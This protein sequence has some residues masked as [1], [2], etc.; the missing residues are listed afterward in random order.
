M[1]HNTLPWR[2]EHACFRAW[3][4]LRDERISGWL[5]RFSEGLTRRANSANP[6]QTTL[7][8]P[9]HLIAACESRYRAHGLPMF[10]RI[11]S[12]ID[13]AMLECLER[14]GYKA[15]G[16]SLVMYG[17][18]EEA[19]AQP[20]D[21]TEL[22]SK[23]NE[24]WL[25][26]MSAL[27]NYTQDRSVTYAKIVTSIAVPAAYISLRDKERIIALAYGAIYDGLL[28][29]ES[30]VTDAAFRGRGNARRMLASL[31][32]WGKAAGAEGLCLQVEASNQPARRLY[33]G[34]G[35]KELYRYHYR[36]EPV[37][38][39]VCVQRL[40]RPALPDRAVVG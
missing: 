17:T 20:D 25:R 6:L 2:I 26:A 28:C 22:L 31:I 9:D 32:D 35:L 37:S 10:F 19:A 7:A 1:N 15:E 38:G 16:E 33:S 12:L 18:M 13:L 8:D 40:A 24:E 5:L 30:V 14:R 4:A 39:R 21:H 27:Q 11:P 34:L 29:F 36:R 23:P 3:P